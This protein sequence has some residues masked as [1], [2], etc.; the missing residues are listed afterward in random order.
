MYLKASKKYKF[1]TCSFNQFFHFS[2]KILTCLSLPKVKSYSRQDM[3]QAMTQHSN[4]LCHGFF[5]LTIILSMLKFNL[6]AGMDY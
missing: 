1:Y 4:Y 2:L 5:M 3:S 6:E